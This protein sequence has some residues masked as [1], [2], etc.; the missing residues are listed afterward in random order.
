MFT[1]H[2]PLTSSVI[3]PNTGN[4]GNFPVQVIKRVP[5]LCIFKITGVIWTVPPP[6]GMCLF[7]FLCV[8]ARVC[9]ACM[10][11]DLRVP[12]A[13]EPRFLIRRMQG[14]VHGT[15]AEEKRL[16]YAARSDPRPSA[17]RSET[18]SFSPHPCLPRG[19][20]TPG[21]HEWALGTPGL[22]LRS[23][24]SSRKK[25]VFFSRK[26]IQVPDQLGSRAQLRASHA[27]SAEDYSAVDG[28]GH[29]GPP[30]PGAP[31]ALPEPSVT[32]EIVVRLPEEGKG[33]RGWGAWLSPAAARA[34]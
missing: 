6:G 25:I 16:L 4:A 8:S 1:F 27:A 33:P 5:S 15:S 30:R 21:F 22:C 10:S 20:F 32:Q 34:L 2:R 28:R 31:P 26:S 23:D 11:W 3:S 12:R 24:K 13:R 17:C 9:A 29:R 18:R 7:S 14:P 19:C